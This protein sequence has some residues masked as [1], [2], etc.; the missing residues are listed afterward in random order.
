MRACRETFVPMTILLSQRAH[1]HT[2]ACYRRLVDVVAD[3]LTFVWPYF[4]WQQ[5]HE[6]TRR[7]WMIHSRDT[8]FRYD[9]KAILRI[10]NWHF[11]CWYD[12]CCA[13]STK[14]R[15]HTN[16]GPAQ[17][18]RFVGA[19]VQHQKCMACWVINQ[20]CRRKRADRLAAPVDGAKILFVPYHSEW[21]FLCFLADIPRSPR[22]QALY[23]NSRLVTDWAINFVRSEER[24]VFVGEYD[25]FHQPDKHT[26][27]SHCARSPTQLLA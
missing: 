26:Q 9:L 7:I 17:I 2:S 12:L 24:F 27:S 13:K 20:N 14:M 10:F 23:H 4:M 22:I 25:S 19:R 1:T 18:S 3:C 21:I 5:R 11:I 8:Y 15:A 6:Q 16:T